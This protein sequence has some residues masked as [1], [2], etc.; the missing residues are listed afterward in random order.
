MMTLLPRIYNTHTHTHTTQ[1]TEA[2]AEGSRWGRSN[3]GGPRIAC[4]PCLLLALAR[5]AKL[6]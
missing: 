6:S 5:P 4:L 3:H 1:Q 2:E